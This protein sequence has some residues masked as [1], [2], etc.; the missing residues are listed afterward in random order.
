M[1]FPQDFE[2]TQ[3]FWFSTFGLGGTHLYFRNGEHNCK[4]EKTEVR[5][6]L[7]LEKFSAMEIIQTTNFNL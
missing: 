7:L 4:A 1:G 6:T 3:E 2:F 5:R